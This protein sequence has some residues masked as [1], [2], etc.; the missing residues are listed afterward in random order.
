MYG[1]VSRAL[2]YRLSKSCE[3]PVLDLP[4]GYVPTMPVLGHTELEV[5]LQETEKSLPLVASWTGQDER[6]DIVDGTTGKK[7]DT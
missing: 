3:D 6:M 2:Y 1:H 4:E 7:M 5:S